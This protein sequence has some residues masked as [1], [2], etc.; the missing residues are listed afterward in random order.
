MESKLEN[1]HYDTI[2]SFTADVHLMLANCRKYN[3]E[4]NTYATQA[5][6]MEKALER[7]LRK[8][9]AGVV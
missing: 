6:R 3:G 9:Q 7:I 4:K 5:N 2:E 1:N 8:R